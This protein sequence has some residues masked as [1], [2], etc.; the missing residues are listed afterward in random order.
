MGVLTLLYDVL[1]VDHMA[2]VVLNATEKE[3]KRKHEKTRIRASAPTLFERGEKG[4]EVE[5]EKMRVEIRTHL[6]PSCPGH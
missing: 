3:E 2:K 4:K 6:I 1:Q 5:K